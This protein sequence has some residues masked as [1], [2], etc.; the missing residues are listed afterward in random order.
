M[1][2]SLRTESRLARGLTALLAVLCLCAPGEAASPSAPGAASAAAEPAVVE[3][4]AP[5][6]G[7]PTHRPLRQNVEAGLPEPTTPRPFTAPAGAPAFKV[8]PR[9][10]QLSILPCSACHATQVPNP[11]PRKLEAP[12]QAA[13]PHGAG[14]FWC[15]ECHGQKDRDTLHTITGAKVDFD[16]SHLVCGQCHSNRHRDWYF[17]AHGKRVATWSG[18]RERFNCTHCHDPHDPTI[19]PRAAGKPPPVR[20][21]LAP[22]QRTP[23]PAV[24]AWERQPRGREASQGASR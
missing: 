20:A 24:P 11:K 16:D 15:L 12:H 1:A 21:G 9:K 10:D 13:L 22:M 18:E 5:A 6:A 17:G 19:R 4:A 3:P 23:H 7:R 2:S 14:R 8:V